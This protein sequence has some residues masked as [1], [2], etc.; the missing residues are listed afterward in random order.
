[1][2]NLFIKSSVKK[3][4]EVAFYIFIDF[5]KIELRFPFVGRRRTCYSKNAEPSAVARTSRGPL[6]SYGL[7]TL[8]SQF[9]SA[10]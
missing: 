8:S 1:M 6:H 4:L 5:L 7:L 3:S 2:I 9:V 10:V